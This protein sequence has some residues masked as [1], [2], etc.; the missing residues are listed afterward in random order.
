MTRIALVVF[1]LAA[2]L[3]PLPA[4][5]V[6][7]WYSRGL[8][9]AIQSTVTP[10]SEPALPIALLDVAAIVLLVAHSVSHQRRVRMR[11]FVAAPSRRTPSR[12]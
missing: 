10:I 2:W 1:A 12:W 3:L 7:A 4:A 5:W 11:G 8:Y 9:P 6:E